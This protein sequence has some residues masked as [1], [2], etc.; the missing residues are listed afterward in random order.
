MGAGLQAATLQRLLAK[1]RSGRI[2]VQQP[3]P[4]LE[5]SITEAM[6]MKTADSITMP[7]AEAPKPFDS[8]TTGYSMKRS[9]VRDAVPPLEPRSGEITRPG[10]KSFD[11]RTP[12]QAQPIGRMT[13]Q[14]VPT[15]TS[16]M[17]PP[18]LPQGVGGKTLFG[19]APS[20]PPRPPARPDTNEPTDEGPALSMVPLPTAAGGAAA[21]PAPP[22]HKQTTAM[23]GPAAL[24]PPAPPAPPPVP[25]PTPAS[26]LP[27]APSSPIAPPT[28]PTLVA[29]APDF[30]LEVATAERTGPDLDSVTTGPDLDAPTGPDLAPAGLSLQP[31]SAASTAK[32]MGPVITAAGIMPPQPL[33]PRPA[34][35]VLEV[36]PR[37]LGIGTVAGFCE[38][39]IR[40]N[41][42]LPAEMK[43]LFTTSRDQQATVRI[44]VC[45]GESRRLDNNVVIGDLVLQDLP[46][47]PRG[48]TSIEVTFS[49]DASG[50]LQ[51][52]ARDAMTGREQRASLDL[53]GGMQD[54]AA[55]RDR[56]QQLRR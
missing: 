6:D 17:I 2:P 28:A 45:Q 51:V 41:S 36:T 22:P 49:V 25:P 14:Q 3:P 33:Q 47:R 29:L 48:E 16:P 15:P 19:V 20:P 8:G 21:R 50:I 11:S 23:P 38:E 1:P 5:D 42:R 40:R 52:R 53:V 54:V 24:R 43:K 46:P 18:P 39:L 7:A 9:G 35:V 34:P 31:S 56:I 10:E 55:S 13:R 27:M 30:A 44:V 32:G 4:E 26:T 37:G 12:P